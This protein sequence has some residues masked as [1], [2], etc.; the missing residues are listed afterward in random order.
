MTRIRL[1]SALVVSRLAPP[2]GVALTPV[3]GALVEELIL[4]TP[5]LPCL[6]LVGWWCG[7]PPAAFLTARPRP[8]QAI[9]ALYG[10]RRQKRV[11]C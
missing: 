6:V 2:F 1:G 8:I 5:Y 3:P 4:T 9:P 10:V 7:S 11:Y